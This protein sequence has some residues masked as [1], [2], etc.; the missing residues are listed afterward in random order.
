[1]GRGAYLMNVFDALRIAMA[2][3]T[4]T[5]TYSRRDMKRAIRALNGTPYTRYIVT[6]QWAMRG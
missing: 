6:I 1:M 2:C 4:N 3:E 5:C